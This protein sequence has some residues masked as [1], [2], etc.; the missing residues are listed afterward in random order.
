M[1]NKL[2]YLLFVPALLLIA[3]TTYPLLWNLSG[4][5]STTPQ[6]NSF[7]ILPKDVTLH[8]FVTIFTKYRFPLY[9]KNTL[10]FA[11]IASTLSAI[12]NSM[13]AYALAR[14]NFP[15]KKAIF[16]VVLSTM[17]IPFSV[18]MI[19]LF[20]II[21]TMRLVN[22]MA[23]LVLPFMASGFGIFLLRQFFLGIPGE[24]EDAAK[25]DGLSFLGIYCHIVLPLSKPIF[26]TLLLTSFLSSWNQ[27]LW[28]LIVNSKEALWVITTGMANFTSD[29]QVNWN[30]LMTGATVSVLP[31]VILF[32]VFQRQLVDG[33]KLSGLK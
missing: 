21:R 20:L 9:I 17:M 25:I 10:I 6:I 23:A 32:A 22:T 33:V 2:R 4:A 13:A 16:L 19:P 28:P 12:F 26:L 7:S 24:L 3:I 30:M 1:N 14:L 18:T 29:R 8:N 11:T 5:I 31:S 15:G 27:Y